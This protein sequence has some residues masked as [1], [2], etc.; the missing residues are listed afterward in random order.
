MRVLLCL[1]G[2]DSEALLALAAGA[3]RLD[4]AAVRLLHVL[5]TATAE[6]A[7]WLRDRYIGRGG[8]GS[9]WRMQLD[10]ASLAEGEALLQTA[11]DRLA[12]LLAAPGAGAPPA[13][14][15][16]L[17]LAGRPERQIVDAAREWPADLVALCAR[18]QDGT[19]PLP[20]PRSVG[21]VARYVSDHAP[22][23]VLLKRP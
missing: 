16:R 15:E 1:D 11:A 9:N 17:L 12:A 6:D 14:V 7:G 8:M 18:R 10:R 2:T 23:P 22:C 5:D 21:H 19:A 3:L 13:T 4:G 20:G